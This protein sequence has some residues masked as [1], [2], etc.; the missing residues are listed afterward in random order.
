MAT[1]SG[2]IAGSNAV[3]MF[4]TMVWQI[5]LTDAVRE[6]VA[7]A[8]LPLLDAL[9]RE[10]PPASDDVAWQSERA[11]HRRAAL[12]ELV[13]CIE[14]GARAVLRFYRIGC[15]AIEITGCWANLY[16]P[17]A[18]QWR[19]Y[20]APSASTRTTVRLW[21]KRF[22]NAGPAALAR[23]AAGRGDPLLRRPLRQRPRPDCRV[24][25]PPAPPF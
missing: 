25:S 14:A 11:L 3:P 1:D 18:A 16:A 21:R 13:A 23:D 8:V 9:R 24:R 22:E 20:R 10:V 12:A 19:T 4:P 5:T 6:R 2:W 15:D 17:G 7:A